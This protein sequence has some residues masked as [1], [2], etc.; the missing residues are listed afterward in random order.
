MNNYPDYEGYEELSRFTPGQLSS[1]R[2]M[3]LEK[4]QSQVDFIGDRLWMP[5]FKKPGLKILEIGSGNGRLL[6]GLH[7]QGLL[8]SG[9]GLDISESRTLFALNWRNSLGID[10]QT[11]DFYDVD[12]LEEASLH[13]RGIVDYS[14]YDLA[15]CI[16]GCFQYFYPIDPE[17]PDKVLNFMRESATY[18]LF[19]LYKRPIMG[20]TWKPLPKDDRWKYI[21]DEYTDVVDW[22]EHRKIFVDHNGQEDVRM[23]YLAYYNMQGFLRKLRN[24][25]FTNVH[26]AKEGR[27]SMVVLV[28]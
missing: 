19:E 18:S 1:Y 10:W 7:Q 23:E 6:I 27:D 3:L 11:L 14:G 16:T 2:Q 4:T 20:R 12:V 26:W 25:G 5:Y 24:A 21:L 28:S 13:M 17:A 9:L 22:V 8:E 15:V